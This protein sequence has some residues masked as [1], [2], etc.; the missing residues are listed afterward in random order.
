MQF[1]SVTYVVHACGNIAVRP[2]I[3]FDI[4][5]PSWQLYR[6]TDIDDTSKREILLDRDRFASRTNAL[7][8]QISPRPSSDASSSS[9]SCCCFLFSF[10]TSHLYF[11][12]PAY[13][14]LIKLHPGRVFQLHFQLINFLLQPV[15]CFSLW[16]SD[17]TTKL[18]L[19]P[20]NSL[21]LLL[22]VLTETTK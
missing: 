2:S 12:L 4:L 21:F 14:M 17:N 3:V 11:V 18:R 6:R 22:S 9:T 1:S 15:Q 16:R 19:L 5:V 7:L 8:T 13:I 10:L 20:T